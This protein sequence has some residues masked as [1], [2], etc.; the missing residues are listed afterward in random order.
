MAAR[1]ASLWLDVATIRNS[2]MHFEKA[3]TG[4]DDIG[5][6]RAGDRARSLAR[7][8]GFSFGRK[9][10]NEGGITAR[11]RAVVNLIAAGK[12]NVEIAKELHI[13]P[14]TVEYH[15]STIFSKANIKRR[16]EISGLIS[17]GLPIV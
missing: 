17:S 13:T 5:A 8:S 4:F 11:E 12:T 15:I 2:R 10:E 7:N 1:R 9:K 14:R 3:I 6:W 16:S